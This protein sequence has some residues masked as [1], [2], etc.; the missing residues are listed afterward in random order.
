MPEK[1]SFVAQYKK[2]KEPFVVTDA[3]RQG[4]KE[5]E[6]SEMVRAGEIGP[7]QNTMRPSKKDQAINS[8]ILDEVDKIIT[9]HDD[10]NA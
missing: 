7:E 1:M 3:M 10:E 9:T 2:I 5:L 4:A 8:K 6:E